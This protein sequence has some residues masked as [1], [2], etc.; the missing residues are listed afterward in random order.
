[1]VK[2]GYLS[3]G[4]TTGRPKERKVHVACAHATSKADHRRQR[5]FKRGLVEKADDMSRGAIPQN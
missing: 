1:S 4:V 5:G 2:E 3:P